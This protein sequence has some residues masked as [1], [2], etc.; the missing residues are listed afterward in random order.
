MEH[1]EQWSGVRR[2]SEV[3]VGGEPPSREV[4]LLLLLGR[5][6]ILRGNIVTHG[7]FYQDFH[8]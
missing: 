6:S 4:I 2:A 7:N 8:L 5:I 1:S 3:P